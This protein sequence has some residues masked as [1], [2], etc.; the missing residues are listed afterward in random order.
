MLTGLP[1]SRRPLRRR[2]LPPRGG[3]TYRLAEPNS[4]LCGSRSPPR[5]LR[6]TMTLAGIINYF[7]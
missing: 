6:C 1:C 5:S 4:N 3:K 2:R 7:G